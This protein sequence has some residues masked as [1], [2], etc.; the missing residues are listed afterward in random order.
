MPPLWITTA[1]ISALLITGGAEA[2]WRRE[3]E[4][5]TQWQRTLD[6]ADGVYV[7]TLAGSRLHGAGPVT[8]AAEA[9]AGSIELVLDRVR[10]SATQSIVYEFRVLETLHGADIESASVELPHRVVPE[11]NT[12][13]DQHRDG[14]FWNDGAVGRSHMSGD[15]S[16]VANFRYG[17]TYILV[18]S[19]AWHVKSFERV[20]SREDQFYTFLIDRFQSD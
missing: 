8:W 5:A 12:D 14:A 4:S 2:C 18:R 19:D 13:F 10:A 16:V 7:V 17:D 1:A 6:Q 15:C 20:T 11:N 9:E 3:A